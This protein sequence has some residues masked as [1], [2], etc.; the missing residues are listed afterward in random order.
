MRKATHPAMTMT[1]A[2]ETSTVQAT[3]P[4][5]VSPPG[6]GGAHAPAY[7]AYTRA[8]REIAK[9]PRAPVSAAAAGSPPR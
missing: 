6:D 2:T 3:F 7:G 8:G 5:I 9:V 4:T 1:A